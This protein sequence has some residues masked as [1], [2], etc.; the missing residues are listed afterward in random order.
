MSKF[1]KMTQ[2]KILTLRR[3]DKIKF[4]TLQRSEKSSITSFFEKMMQSQNLD[5]QLK[6]VIF[7]F[8][9]LFFYSIIFINISS[10]STG[11]IFGYNDVASGK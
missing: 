5:F 7:L 1:Q 6:K 9:S 10:Y 2:Y 11:K 3:S 4:L 8:F